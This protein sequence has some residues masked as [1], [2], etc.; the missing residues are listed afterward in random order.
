[1][2]RWR[3]CSNAVVIGAASESQ[4][5]DHYG[6][7]RQ[8][9]RST[10]LPR[11]LV[12][13][14]HRRHWRSHFAGSQL[15]HKTKRHALDLVLRHRFGRCRSWHFSD[16]LCQAPTL[17][18]AAILDVWV[19]SIA[20]EQAAVLSLGLSLRFI[21]SRPTFMFIFGAQTGDIDRGMFVRGMEQNQTGI[22][23]SDISFP[24]RFSGRFLCMTILWSKSLRPTRGLQAR[25]KKAGAAWL[26]DH[27]E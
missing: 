20:R 10:D 9:Q 4:N 13:L 5:V 18:A 26:P 2:P 8:K 3:R 7:S 25:L 11:T 16:I 27:A 12:V 15:F 17:S 22:Y 14:V 1:M 21:C 23:S 6:I 24:C 19:S